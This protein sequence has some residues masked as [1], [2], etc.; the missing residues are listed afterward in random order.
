MLYLL[1]A[2]HP[3]GGTGSNS[4]RHYLG[5]CQP[6]HLN[7]RLAQHRSGRGAKLT[8][9]YM[10]E[11]GQVLLLARVWPVG[12]RELETQLKHNGH[13]AH[14]C[15]ICRPE[16]PIRLARVV[17]PIPA[18]PHSKQRSQRPG[19]KSGGG[20]SVGKPTGSVT[21][22]RQLPLPESGTGWTNDKARRRMTRGS[23]ATSARA[24]QPR[25]GSTWSA[26]TRRRVSYG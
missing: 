21:S 16:L 26:G 12:T 19:S 14:L 23:G 6:E 10:K 15:P 11:P 3:V 7:Q 5:F 1:H 8:I 18:S 20:S 9:A 17:C 24:R 25:R 22:F 13:L 4:A 2:T